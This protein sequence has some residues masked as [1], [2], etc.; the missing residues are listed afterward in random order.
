M[1]VVSVCGITQSGKTTTVEALISGLKRRGYC[2]GSVKEIHYEKFAIDQD[3][4]SNTHRHR[5][6]GAELVTARGFSETDVLFPQ[7]LSMEKI[8]SFYDGFDWVV[9]EGVD[10]IAVPTIVTA[11]TEEDMNLKW[12]DTTFAVS[13][14]IADSIDEYRGVPAISA[15]ADP[16]ALTA[17]V[18]QK[19]YDILPDFDPDCCT[20]CGHTCRTLGTEI[21]NGRASRDDCVADRGVTLKID[22]RRVNMVPFV[23]RILTNAMLGVVSELE[24]Y[25]EGAKVEVE[26]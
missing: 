14:R 20:A 10:D 23:Q 26:L 8:L 13:G 9:L 21:L 1:K 11:H 3:P 5:K 25:R 7:K 17:L 2:V 6:A 24:G 18:L 15:V 12:G 16:D 19:V 22:G 4:A